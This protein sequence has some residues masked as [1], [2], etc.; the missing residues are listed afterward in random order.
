MVFLELEA[1]WN[2]KADA[3]LDSAFHYDPDPDP[4]FQSY[5]K[6]DPVPTALFPRFG[7]S[8]ATK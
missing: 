4:A 1:L 5:A 7:L 2:W 6:P 3:D 8:N